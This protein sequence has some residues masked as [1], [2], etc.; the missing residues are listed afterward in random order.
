MKT[1]TVYF[2]SG[3]F[4]NFAIQV[5]G[6][7][8]LMKFLK[9]ANSE[10]Y[11]AARK[12]LRDAASNPVLSDAKRRANAIADDGTYAGSLTVSSRANGATWLL[13]SDD[14]AAP[15]K[16][17]AHLGARTISTK[18]TKLANARFRKRSGVGVPR[19]AYAPR[20]MVPAVNDNSEKV[21]SRIDAELA[22]IMERANG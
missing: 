20:A 21:K 11:K 12:G 8:R 2:Q 19:R 13:K 10:L 16:E 1:E 4:G 6:L 18:G 17:F 3:E 7:D 14:P 15:V 9:T 5:D 22:K